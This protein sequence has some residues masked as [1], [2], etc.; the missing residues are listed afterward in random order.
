ML[1]TMVLNEQ[2]RTM[3]GMT[4]LTCGKDYDCL[5]VSF[6]PRETPDLAR[7]KREHYLRA[8]RRPP[9]DE[10]WHFLTGGADA[11]RRLTQTVGFRYA[12]DEKFHQWAHPSGMII[13]TPQGQLSRYFYGIDYTVKDVRLSLVEASQNKI[14]SLA[15]QVLLLCYHYDPATGTYSLAIL[16]LLKGAAGLTLAAVAAYLVVNFRRDFKAARRQ[17]TEPKAV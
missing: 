8:Y 12:W 14:G 9:A 17:T 5:T 16:N 13:L 10:G 4:S 6:D 15:E 2:L 7:A 3:N 1:C 11:I